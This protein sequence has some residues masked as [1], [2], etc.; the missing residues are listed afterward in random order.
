MADHK[1]A[2]ERTQ[3]QACN[4]AIPKCKEEK[5]L[6]RCCKEIYLHL[7]TKPISERGEGPCS[8]SRDQFMVNSLKL[9]IGVSVWS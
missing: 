7:P 8:K 4:P 3:G 6:R 9:S 5:C 2:A 1:G